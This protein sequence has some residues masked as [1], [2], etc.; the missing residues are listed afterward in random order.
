[1]GDQRTPQRVP[2]RGQVE[3][4]RGELGGRGGIGST[5]DRGGLECRLDR[6]VIARFRSRR[7]G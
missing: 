6:D 1:L 2:A 3:R 4:L 5:Q 7:A